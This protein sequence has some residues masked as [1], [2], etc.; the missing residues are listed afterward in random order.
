MDTGINPTKLEN[1]T[2]LLYPLEVMLKGWKKAD[3]PTMKKLPVEVDVVEYLVSRA[4]NKGGS[5]K[6]RATADLELAAFYYLLR[7][8]EY[9]SKGTRNESKQTVQFRWEDVTFF[10]RDSHGRLK[11]M[12]RRATDEQIMTADSCTLRLTFQKN[13]WKGVCINH[14]ANG[15]EM[16]CPVRAIGRR[17]IHIRSHTSDISTNLSAYFVNGCKHEVTDVNVRESL[18]FAATQLNYPEN[19]GIPIERIDTHSLRIGG[20]NALSLAGY[21]DRE[22]QKM[23]RWRSQTFKEYVQEQLSD[24]SEGMSKSMKQMFNFVNVEG[25][26]WHDITQTAI[27]LPYSPPAANAA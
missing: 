3:P 20:A 14:H 24:F 22:I 11:Q 12:S 7:V 13:G 8:G 18:K 26:V 4:W 6:D 19:K 21:S 27:N 2:K 10:K 17:I 23:G 9:T 5:E 25:G 16:L 15:D 1:S